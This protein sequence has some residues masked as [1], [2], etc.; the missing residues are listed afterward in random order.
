MQ[1]KL[2][3]IK[4]LIIFN[5]IGI[6]ASPIIYLTLFNNTFVFTDNWINSFY[7]ES[8]YLG[9]ILNSSAKIIFGLPLHGI[10][11]FFSILI[12]IIA[13]IRIYRANR[14]FALLLLCLFIT[15]FFYQLF[16]LLGMFNATGRLYFNI[17]HFVWLVPFIVMM[18]C[19]GLY[20]LIIEKKLYTKVIG[21][22]L[23][24]FIV[25]CN[26]FSLPEVSFGYTAPAYKKSVDYIAQEIRDNDLVGM[27]VD[28]F[29]YSFEFNGVSFYSKYA[30]V[31]QIKLSD[32]NALRSTFRRIFI[33]IPHEDYYGFPQASITALNNYVVSLKQKLSLLKHWH[34]NK[35]DVYLFAL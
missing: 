18:Y 11:L 34:D 24:I 29:K 12:P 20:L 2:S 14:P 13:L 9:T 22:F 33:I 35:I 25:I 6:V 32:I 5:F 16:F 19:Y 15:A 27:P 3:F 1:I 10:P 26:L 21:C 4:S 17:R 23:S 28:W 30:R 7:L 31:C 8:E